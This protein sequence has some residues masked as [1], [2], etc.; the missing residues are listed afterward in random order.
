LTNPSD[1]AADRPQPVVAPRISV[2]LP[3]FM[4]RPSA[5]AAELLERAIDS[6]LRQSYPADVELLLI[7][8]GSPLPVADCIGRMACGEDSRL[9]ILRAARNNGVAHALNLGLRNARYEWIGRIDADDRWMPGKIQRQMERLAADPRITILGTGMTMGNGVDGSGRR[10]IRPDGWH[11]MLRFAADIGCPFPHGSILGRADIFG[12]LAGYPQGAHVAHCEDYALWSVWLRFFKPAMIEAALY[13]YRISRQAVSARHRKQQLKATLAIRSELR[14]LDLAQRLPD[15]MA[16]LAGALG[17]SLL[18]AGVLCYRIWAFRPPVRL[19]VEAL[20]ILPGIL[21][22]RR[23]LSLDAT[24][25]DRRPLDMAAL[26]K[27][28]DPAPDPGPSTGLAMVL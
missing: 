7:D 2:L 16:E 27:G 4:A 8:D 11:A 21:P 25:E 20:A 28:F 24:L 19:P 26:L 13:D 9:R 23:I 15:D 14:R 6:V 3:V 1:L 22:D 12:L 17:I 10:V 5:S 18:Q